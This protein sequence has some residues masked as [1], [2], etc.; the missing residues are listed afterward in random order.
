MEGGARERSEDSTE[1]DSNDLFR[2]NLHIGLQCIAGE[3]QTRLTPEE[4]KDYKKHNIFK[5]LSFSAEEGNIDFLF[6]LFFFKGV[7]FSV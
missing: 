6:T 5:Q 4:E 3:G 7:S 1:E 2:F